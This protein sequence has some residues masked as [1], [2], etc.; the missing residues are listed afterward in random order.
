MKGSAEMLLQS[1]KTAGELT[2]Q[3]CSPGGTTL[4]ALSAFDERDFD[5]LIEDAM[6]RCTNRSREL[7]K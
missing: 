2:R 5:G 3:V 1:G 4:A 7:G 6:T